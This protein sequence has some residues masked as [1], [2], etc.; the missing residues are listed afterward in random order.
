MAAAPVD[1]QSPPLAALPGRRAARLFAWLPRAAW[2]VALA[3]AGLLA[4]GATAATPG[5]VAFAPG[6][7]AAAP[8]VSARETEAPRAMEVPPRPE[9]PHRSEAA[10]AGFR[11]AEGRRDWVF[12]RDHGQHPAYLLEW[13][14]Y[15]GI[16]ENNRGRRFGFQLTFF[17]KGLAPFHRRRSAWAVRSLYLA[18]AALSDLQAG[19][20]L[21]AGLV[22]RDSLGLS[23]A[24]PDR[25]G[26][27]LS[28]WRADPLPDDPH[29]VRLTA[30]AEDFAFDL[31]LRAAEPPILHG[32]NGLDRKGDRPGQAS[33]YYSLPRLRTEGFITVGGKRHRVRGTTWMDHEFGTNQLGERQV[34]WDWFAI[35]LDGG[36]ALMLYRLRLADG[37]SDPISGGSLIPLGGGSTRLH[38]GREGPQGARLMPGRRWRSPETGGDYPVEWRI[39]L[40]G[41]RLRLKVAPAFDD[42]ELRPGP[43]I[44][45]PYWEGVITVSGTRGG[46]PVKGQ[47]YMELTGYAGNLRDA[48]R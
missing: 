39:E 41:L 4:P 2:L 7:V 46:R 23:G 16:V 8:A 10:R 24:R 36:E 40:P 34:G 3:F 33:W 29:G 5:T 6:A 17:R 22:G 13:W 37:R 19:R 1:P 11:R 20:H 26:V 32:E 30:G 47:G 12:P 25:H 14:Y 48:F 45:F 18:H 43:G 21:Q 9:A 15:T 28:P 35:R 42:Q 27:W 38:L 44:P 31:T